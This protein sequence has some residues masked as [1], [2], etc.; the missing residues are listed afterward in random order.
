MNNSEAGVDQRQQENIVLPAL[1]WQKKH[2]IGVITH[3]VRPE[4][5]ERIVERATIKVSARVEELL[6]VLGSGERVVL[7]TRRNCPIPAGVDGII[8]ESEDGVLAWQFH[9]E[10]VGQ[11]DPKQWVEKKL[12][13][14]ESW[15]SGI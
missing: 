2:N 13:V 7:T 9:R 5:T 3:V 4:R 10:L 1:I 14:S 6:L 15:G 12:S 8:N 11:D